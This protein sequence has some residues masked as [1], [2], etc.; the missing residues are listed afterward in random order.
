[1]KHKQKKLSNQKQN[2]KPKANIRK[3][4]NFDNTYITGEHWFNKIHFLCVD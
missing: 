3:A 1:M 4:N 2:N